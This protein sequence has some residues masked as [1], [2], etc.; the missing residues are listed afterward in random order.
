MQYKNI[1]TNTEVQ[2]SLINDQWA[3]SMWYMGQQTLNNP[4]GPQ[5]T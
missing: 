5:F 2:D 1:L 3:L 4:N